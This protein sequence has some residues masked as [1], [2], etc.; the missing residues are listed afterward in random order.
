MLGQFFPALRS[1]PEHP[2]LML[3]VRCGHT[4]RVRVC[5]RTNGLFVLFRDIPGESWVRACLNCGCPQP[6]QWCTFCWQVLAILG[7]W[8]S[9]LGRWPSILGFWDVGHQLWP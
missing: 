2:W 1:V 6:G 7:R 3:T 9:T 5:Y 4:Y 8:P